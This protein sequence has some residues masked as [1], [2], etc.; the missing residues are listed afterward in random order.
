MAYPQN[1]AALTDLNE[2]WIRP[3]P[4]P[5]WARN[6]LCRENFFRLLFAADSNDRCNTFAE[7]FG[8]GLFPI[9]L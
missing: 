4:R 9:A 5:Q 3:F 8:W 2:Q 7:P 1:R 6:C